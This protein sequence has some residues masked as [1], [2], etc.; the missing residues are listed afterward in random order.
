MLKEKFVT[1]WTL[2]LD[3]KCYRGNYYFLYMVKL[4]WILLVLKKREN[5]CSFFLSLFHFCLQRKCRL[6]RLI[7]SPFTIRTCTRP[8][9]SSHTG[10][11]Q[12]SYIQ[13]LIKNEFSSLDWYCHVGLAN[14]KI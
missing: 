4:N 13:W 1:R 6:C 5:T 7:P 10:T 11:N 14:N 3:V 9:M 12:G 8:P 2:D